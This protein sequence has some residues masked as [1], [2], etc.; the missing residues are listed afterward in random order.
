MLA[1]GAEELFNVNAVDLYVETVVG[2]K[3]RFSSFWRF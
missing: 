1:L 3:V 2:K